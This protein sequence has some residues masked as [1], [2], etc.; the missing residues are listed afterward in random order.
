MW[1]SLLSAICEALLVWF[2]SFSSCAAG[3]GGAGLGMCG[4][5]KIFPSREYGAGNGN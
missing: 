2:F 1:G 3:S 4:T 5:K